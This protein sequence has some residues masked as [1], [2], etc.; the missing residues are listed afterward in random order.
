[1]KKC[2]QVFFVLVFGPFLV[3]GLLYEMS[4]TMFQVGQAMARDMGSK[5]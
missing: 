5:L 1:M 4:A 2:G 3:A